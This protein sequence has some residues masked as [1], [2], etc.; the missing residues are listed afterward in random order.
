MQIIMRVIAV[1]LLLNTLSDICNHTI[2]EEIQEEELID[3]GGGNFS[4][5]NISRDLAN[6]SGRI[7][8]IQELCANL[9]LSRSTLFREFKRRFGMNPVEFQLRHKL[10]N[11]AAMLLHS[12]SSIGDIA[13]QYHFAN[14]AHFA[15]LFRKEFGMSPREYRTAHRRK[16]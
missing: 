2:Q 12:N 5:S 14:A 1:T 9:G 3:G 10:R 15:M 6:N 16:K 4:F 7:I 8:P 11:A 13:M